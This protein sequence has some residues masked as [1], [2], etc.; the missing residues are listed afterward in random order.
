MDES[1][2]ERSPEMSSEDLD[3]LFQYINH[4]FYAFAKEARGPSFVKA[5]E[6]ELVK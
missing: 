5:F 6:M 2:Y 3:G 1:Q 4:Y